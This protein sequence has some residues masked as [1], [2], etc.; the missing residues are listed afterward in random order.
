MCW[1]HWGNDGLWFFDAPGHAANGLFWKDFLL[2]LSFDPKGYALSYHARY[3][4]INPTKHPPVFYILE[5]VFFGGLTPSP[6]V[7][8]GLVLGFALMAALYTTAWCRRWIDEDAGWAGVLLILL[9]GVVRW[10]HAIMPNVPALALSIGALYHIRRWLESPRAPASPVWR[11]LYVGAT[12]AVLSILT[13]LTS[14]VLLLIAGIWLIVE[15]R[16]RLL[17]NRKTL[18]V[19]VTF[20]LALIPWVIVVLK[21]EPHRIKMATG[22]TEIY[23][24][25]NWA[26]DLWSL[27]Y[28]LRCIPE[29]FGTHLLIIAALGIAG[30]MLVRR[31]R[32]ETVLLMIM[33]VVT[34][35]FFWYMPAKEGRYILLLS[36]PIVIFCMLGL[37]S[38]VHCINKLARFRTAWARAV[39]I[40][41]VAVLLTA[42]GWLASK[43]SV[44]SVSGHKQLVEYLE[45]VAPD[46]PVFYDGKDWE[47]F[48]F[49]I[50]AGDP[51]YRRRVVLGSKLLY[52]QSW[53]LGSQEFVSSAQEVVEVLQ[54]RGGC[55]WVV[56]ADRP[57]T[58][59]VTA[60]V[61]LR[62]AVEGPQFELVKSFPITRML[63]T[64][65]D[66][67][68]VCV[69]RFLVPIERV[70]QVDMPF[71]GR[72][73]NLYYQSKPIQR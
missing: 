41:T 68:S 65:V 28:Y 56:V 31:W 43:V 29:L 38:I 24:D 32:H 73:E 9:P 3:P 44:N 67:T 60:P 36:L 69:Y 40:I 5:A 53:W 61:F 21:F 63:T 64:G 34:Y 70:D 15:R 1:L 23:T 66:K 2:S 27:T 37:L 14:C 50:Q 58:S 55:K 25:F 33:T 46:E 17:W 7:A 22:S 71:F 48:I 20:T 52:A 13:Y 49:H 8:K 35:I 18:A 10:S 12:L 30:G 51:D 72:G 57:A 39:T 42:Q 45:K 16:W 47:C 26:T 62:K 19:F 4:V 11:H 6:Y 54:K 59:K